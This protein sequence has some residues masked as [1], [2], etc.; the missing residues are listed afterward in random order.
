MAGLL[1]SFAALSAL[2]LH[3]CEAG[4]VG[5]REG[6]EVQSRDDGIARDGS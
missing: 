4:W 5:V 6:G 2:G 3:S 1:R